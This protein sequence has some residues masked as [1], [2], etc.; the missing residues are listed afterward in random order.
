MLELAESD[1]QQLRHNDYQHDDIHHNDTQHKGLIYA[2]QYTGHSALITQAEQ[3]S[4]I[5]LS[6]IMLSVNFYL[7]LWCVSLC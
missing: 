5:I 6:V 4:T 3:H 2:T 7:L 1:C